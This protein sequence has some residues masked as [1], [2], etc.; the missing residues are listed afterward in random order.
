MEI[1]LTPRAEELLRRVLARHPDQS[2]AEIL[3]KTLAEQVEREELSAGL[4]PA[5]K[6]TPREFDQWLDAFTQ[7]S[8]KI[9]PMPGET[10]SREMI[11]Q[12]HD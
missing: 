10:F 1:T 8:D 12:D 7:F 11:Y 6:L 2:A 5:K 9:P 3:E 4:P